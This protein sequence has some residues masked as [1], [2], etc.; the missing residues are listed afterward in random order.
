MPTSLGGVVVADGTAVWQC[1][2]PL[3]FQ[4][5][6]IQDDGTIVLCMNATPINNATGLDYALC[7]GSGYYSESSADANTTTIE[8]GVYNNN[9]ACGICS[10]SSYSDCLLRGQASD[11]GVC[12]ISFGVQNDLSI[13]HLVIGSYS[14]GNLCAHVILACVD[15]IDIIHPV[16]SSTPMPV[17]QM[18]PSS[19]GA[20]RGNSTVGGIVDQPLGSAAYSTVPVV[21]TG[22]AKLFQVQGPIAFSEIS[23]AS[24]GSSAFQFTP[25]QAL[26]RAACYS[27]ITLV[28]NPTIL[29]GLSFGQTL[30]IFNYGGNPF[31]LDASCGMTL[32]ADFVTI[33]VTNDI[34]FWWDG[35][36]WRQKGAVGR[37]TNRAHP[38]V[39]VN[40]AN[41]DV[42]NPGDVIVTINDV[43]VTG[44]FSI[45]GIVAGRDKQELTILNLSTQTMTLKDRHF[46]GCRRKE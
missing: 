28:S 21:S 10:T 4:I 27:P 20:W 14:E 24:I 40:G 15:G 16:F 30:R 45:T 5:L 12:G 33:E 34:E 38:I 19:W 6:N 1:F 35:Y 18:R 31:T 42:P 7:V 26:I 41:N 25:D 8:G 13:D 43:M 17:Y 22:L 32:E 39:V 46:Q 9:A 11:N 2:N 29:P 23:T 36:T 37:G 3:V 44:A